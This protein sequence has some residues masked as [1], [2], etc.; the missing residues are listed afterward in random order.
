MSSPF[1]Q[2]A[3]VAVA[4]QLVAAARRAGADAAE[5]VAVRGVSQSVEVRQGSVEESALSEDDDVGLRVLIG[6]AS[7]GRVDQ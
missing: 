2:S 5:A 4:E 7:G 6:P 1:D 3:L